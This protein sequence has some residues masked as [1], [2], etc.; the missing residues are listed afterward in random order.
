MS[1]FWRLVLAHLLSDFLFHFNFIYHLKNTKVFAG[2]FVHGIVFFLTAIICCNN[3]LNIPWIQFG[4][5]S[6]NGM[7]SIFI[8]AVLHALLDKINPS[9]TR[10]F[11]GYNFFLFLLWQAIEIML[12]FIV[13]PLVSVRGESFIVGDKF[14]FIL[15]G[16]LVSTYFFMVLI[17]L[18]KRD[19]CQSTYP[20]FDERFVSTLY[21]L[22]LYL[23]FLIPSFWGYALGL[24][25]I[26]LGAVL[27]K[28][29]VIDT[30]PYRLYGGTVITIIFTLIMR[31][32]I[33][34]L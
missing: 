17:Y 27:K 22:A 10:A 34:H 7:Q 5:L 26:F 30:C 1:I 11:N 2:Y 20:I 24:L 9:E 21:R 29:F 18:F 8:L 13:A 31:F 16:V 23:L 4:S 32:F 33:Y 19:F 3:F 28:P 25:W 6:L 14:I 15:I 12:L